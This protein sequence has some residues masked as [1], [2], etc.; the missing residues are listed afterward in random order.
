MPLKLAVLAECFHSAWRLSKP[1][2]VAS[3]RMKK[4]AYVNRAQLLPSGLHSGRAVSQLAIGMHCLL[5]GAAGSRVTCQQ[6][7]PTVAATGSLAERRNRRIGLRST[8]QKASREAQTLA[9]RGVRRLPADPSAVPALRVDILDA[10]SVCKPCSLV[11]RNATERPSAARDSKLTPRACAAFHPNDNGSLS[12]QEARRRAWPAP[13]G[14]EGW[15]LGKEVPPIRLPKECTSQI[16]V[17][18]CVRGLPSLGAAFTLRTRAHRA[19]PSCARPAWRALQAAGLM[20]APMRRTRWTGAAWA[21][22]C[23]LVGCAGPQD[24]CPCAVRAPALPLRHC[25]T[26]SHASS[27]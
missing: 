14:P 6:H 27:A 5:L 3:R 18:V 16:H 2:L 10:S 17:G 23:L 9:L 26:S 20:R 15:S 19:Q 4:A 8:S 24:A 12:L 13:L 11:S 1:A 22:L 7:R 21:V 25:C